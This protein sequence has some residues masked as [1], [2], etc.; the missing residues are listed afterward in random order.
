[1][2]VSYMDFTAPTTQFT[3]TLSD[4]PFF[5]KDN[6]NY[7]NALSINQLNTLGNASLLDIYLS[8]QNVVEPHIHQ[9]ATELVY[10]I[11]GAAVVS[12]VNPFSKELLNFP[13]RPGQVANVP[14]G[15]W[16]YEIATEDNT[17]LLAIFDAPVPEFIPGSDLLRLTPANILAHT[18]C[19]NEALV[20]EALS[21][22]SE[23]VVIGP[24]KDCH[25]PSASQLGK[26]SQ[27]NQPSTLSTNQY[28]Q[29]QQ[30]NPADQYAYSNYG[31]SPQAYNQSFPGISSSNQMVSS[32]YASQSINNPQSYNYPAVPVMPH[33]F[34]AHYSPMSY[35]ANVQSTPLYD[36]KMKGQ[37]EP[38]SKKQTAQMNPII[39]NG[40]R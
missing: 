36:G 6:Q 7:I 3:Y 31:G 28:S 29:M 39:G 9:N 4:N 12:I 20:K 11:T 21:P 13:I 2:A 14:Q 32:G 16:H 8:R 1:M 35:S 23:T 19:L 17:H 24:P 37:V 5:K 30:A 18:Y 27:L 10:C 26:A 33:S 34:P 22:I 25:S 15:W 38:A 40:G